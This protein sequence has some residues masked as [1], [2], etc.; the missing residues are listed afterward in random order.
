MREVQMY[1]GQ[2]QIHPSDM[3]YKEEHFFSDL[4]M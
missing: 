4:M 1:L 3:M 2:T